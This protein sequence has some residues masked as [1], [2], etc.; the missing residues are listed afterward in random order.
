[1][2]WWGK[3][4]GGAFGFMLGGPLGALLGVALGRVLA[5]EITHAVAPDCP[6]TATGLMDGQ[7]TR[8]MPTAPGVGFDETATW[9]LR[10]G[11]EAFG[12][13]QNG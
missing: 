5:P 9:H 2:S 8:R 11:A 1:M 4:A 3:L 6:H 10:R 13:A 7:L 12:G